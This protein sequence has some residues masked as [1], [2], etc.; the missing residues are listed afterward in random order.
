MFMSKVTG[1][2]RHLIWSYWSAWDDKW[3]KEVE[4]EHPE[5]SESEIYELMHDDNNLNLEADR[6]NL[7]IQFS[8]PIILIADIGRW[9][10]R[11]KGYKMIDSGNIKDCLCSYEEGVAEWYVDDK[12]DLRGSDAHHDATHYYL[13]RVFKSGITEN[14]IENFQ[15]KILNGSLT[16]ADITR[17]TKRLGDEIADVFGWKIPRQRKTA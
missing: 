6:E 4:Q 8:Q 14:Q 13:Y 11:F 1:D 5:L 17:Y 2:T 10:G 15:N 7:D 12:G 16:R 9:N 3:K